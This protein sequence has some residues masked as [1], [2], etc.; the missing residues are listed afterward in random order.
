MSINL[1][2]NVSFGI[3][4]FLP[5]GWVFMIL[6]MLLESFIMSELLCKSKLNR[7]ITA[8]VFFSNFISGI[9]GIVTTMIINGGWVLVVW[10]PWVSSHEIDISSTH[11]LIGFMV[12][13][14]VAFILSVLIELL[15]NHFKL[16]KIYPAGKIVKATILANIASYLVG[17]VALYSYSFS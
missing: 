4:A 1:L 2:L 7:R 13:Y 5:Q 12:F 15:I 17:S 9:F 6:I 11:E 14:F 3:F 16:R 10:F 8:I